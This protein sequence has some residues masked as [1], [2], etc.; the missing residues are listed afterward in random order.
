MKRKEE[1]NADINS[2]PNSEGPETVHESLPDATVEINDQVAKLEGELTESKDKYLRMYSEFENYKKRVSKE[3]M[4]QSRF[5]GSDMLLSFLPVIDDLERASKSVE[6]SNDSNAVKDG[7]KLIYSKIKSIAE[8]KGLKEMISVN[9][10]FDPELHDAIANT[11][12]LT[13][14]MKGKVVEEI[15]KG[16]Y[17]NER[18]I[19]HA[20]VI[21]GN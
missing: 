18:V 8:S 1:L 9:S 12:A 20:K 10:L 14:D 13:D 21:V 15:E 5:A 16:Y 19:R 11:K 2:N 3:R 7:L 17:L 4:E 6:D